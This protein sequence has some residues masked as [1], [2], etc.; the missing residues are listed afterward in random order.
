[1]LMILDWFAEEMKR[2]G[3]QTWRCKNKA[4]RAV[5]WL[6]SDATLEDIVKGKG[7]V[8][9]MRYAHIPEAEC[10]MCESRRRAAEGFS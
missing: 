3:H 2:K 5:S 9:L 7:A 4:C 6:E 10:P 1:M 8:V